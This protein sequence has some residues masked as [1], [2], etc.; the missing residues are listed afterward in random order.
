MEEFFCPEV[1]MSEGIKSI[2]YSPRIN[3][4]VV[5]PGTAVKIECEDGIAIKTKILVEKN[6]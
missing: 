4:K 5:V 1:P 6:Y 2:K 3:N